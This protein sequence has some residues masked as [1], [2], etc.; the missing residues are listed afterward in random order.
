ME[1]EGDG[2][3][4]M[5]TAGERERFWGVLFL[6][7]GARRWRSEAYR[8]GILILG[9]GTLRYLEPANQEPVIRYQF[10]PGVNPANNLREHV[11]PHSMAL[12]D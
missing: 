9:N 5:R 7:I 3:T 10:G 6:T 1:G 4:A 11:E 2:E 12:T 8:H